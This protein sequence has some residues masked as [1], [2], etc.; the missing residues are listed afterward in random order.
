MNK[1]I[2][3]VC[4]TTFP[5]TA[6]RCPICGCAKQPT[7]QSVITDD[8]Q[9]LTESSGSNTYSKGGRFAKSNVKNAQQAKR[10]TRSAATAGRFSSD[11][12]QNSE[13]EIGSKGLIAVVIILL[14]AI[15]MVVVYIG[16]KVFFP[17][18]Q[19]DADQSGNTSTVAPA[20]DNGGPSIPCTEIKL[21]SS[22]IHLQQAN[23]QFLLEVIKKTPDNTT[24]V[25][26]FESADPT[27][28]AVSDTGMVTPVGY[29]TTTIKVTCGAVIAECTVVS[30]VGDPPETTPPTT[31]AVTLP[32]GFKLKLK[33]YKD[34]GEIT[35]SA[36]Y[37]DA[38]LYTTTNGVTASDI[39]WTISDPAIA[40]VEKGKAIG[41]SKGT[42]TITATIGD[43]T[44]TCKVIVTFDAP[45]PTPYELNRTD[46]TL[47]SGGGSDSFFS[48]SLKEIETGAKMSVEWHVDK[49]GV[50]E[51]SDSGKVTACDVTAST[52][53]NVYT[54]YDGVTYTCIFRVHP[55]SAKD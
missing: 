51:V 30:E 39:T 9:G 5:E 7:A 38:T 53:V 14:L 26:K 20:G 6:T 44:A 21:N 8:S 18:L 36:E 54:E 16:V 52:T 49:E 45:E 17:E 43:Q 13:P 23:Q 50:V 34:S 24:D 19:S 37:P 41:L 29:G 3:D 28:A 42:C 48:L 47:Y 25:V 40:K 22:T 55:A 27:I 46:V 4:G 1:V 11:R 33:T 15:V 10:N 2:C 31:P 12:K 35:L 32:E